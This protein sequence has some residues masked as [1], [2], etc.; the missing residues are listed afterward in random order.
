MTMDPDMAL[1]SLRDWA[2]NDGASRVE[3]DE[4]DAR[5]Y[6]QALDQWLVSGGF[7]PRAWGRRGNI[8]V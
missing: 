8:D 4:T 5:E 2:A 6:F 7:Y 1:A 3:I